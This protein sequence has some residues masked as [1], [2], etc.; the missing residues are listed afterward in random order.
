MYYLPTHTHTP[1]SWGCLCAACMHG[2]FRGQTL[3]CPQRGSLPMRGPRPWRWWCKGR[4]DWM[5]PRSMSTPSRWLPPAC[6]CVRVCVCVYIYHICMS[7]CMYITF[8]RCLSERPS[9]GSR[10]WT[11]GVSPHLSWNLCMHACM[12]VYVCMQSSLGR[13]Y[14]RRAASRAWHRASRRIPHM[15][16]WTQGAAAGTASLWPWS[17]RSQNP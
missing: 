4:K 10:V 14:H 15:L 5:L 6:A 3:R 9:G 11:P 2:A 12:H 8:T 13:T 17:C 16:R 7:V 1:G